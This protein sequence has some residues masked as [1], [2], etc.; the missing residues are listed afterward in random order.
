MVFAVAKQHI[1]VKL[2]AQNRTRS[3]QQ[4][5][6]SKYLLGESETMEDNDSLETVPLTKTDRVNIES[7]YN[8]CLEAL[9]L[10]TPCTHTPIFMEA[11]DKNE[12]P[13]APKFRWL[14]GSCDLDADMENQDVELPFF[15]TPEFAKDVESN[16]ESEKTNLLTNS[17]T[18]SSS[19]FSPRN[20]KT[21]EDTMALIS[22]S[23]SWFERHLAF[24]LDS[25]LSADDVVEEE[26]WVVDDC[27]EE[28][29]ISK[30]FPPPVE[31]STSADR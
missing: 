4:Q 15:F 11:R 17:F 2:M 30:D 25:V 1:A 10:S 7:S 16:Q 28:F 19:D 31:T 13:K 12:S 29:S 14:R 20:N 22:D 18:R 24:D 26:D 23:G 5:D 9:Y 6:E 21:D 8:R 27:D 3:E